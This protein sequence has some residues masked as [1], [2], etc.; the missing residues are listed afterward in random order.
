MPADRVPVRTPTASYD[1]R[2]GDRLLDHLGELGRSLELGPKV[3][4]VVDTGLPEDVIAR[5]SGALT[6]A[7]FDVRTAHVEP[8]EPN[9]TL[10]TT[11]RLCRTFAAHAIERT[12]TVVALGGGVVGDTAG[13]AAAVYRRGCR[14]LQCPTTLLSM[15]D[16]SVGGKTGVNLAGDD[17]HVRKNFVGAFLH[18][19]GVVADVG[20]LRSLP[21]RDLRA[22]AA[23]CVK[24]G[25][26]A[27]SAIGEAA[28]DFVRAQSADLP[29]AL[30]GDPEAATR[31][32]A[33]NVA[34]K[35]AV[36]AGDERETAHA[37]GRALL[38][39]GH[40]FAHVI[41]PMPACATDAGAG[42]LRHGEAVAI[43]LVAAS[44]CSVAL[45][46]AP[47]GFVDEARERL[48]GAGLP[49]SV[50]NLPPVDELVDAM[51]HD[52]KATAGQLRIVVPE[53]AHEAR[54]VRA[55]DPAALAA[56]WRAVEG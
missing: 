13:F 56:G 19:V 27:R 49:T 43:G 14:V 51:A 39:L 10:E 41:E 50:R 45:G 2:I 46:L 48:R 30:A 52:K 37:G 54:V 12:D 36:V 8:G 16:A 21:K 31:T 11:E 6:G 22:G 44:A 18:P 17:G 23:E 34:L 38:N 4:L 7:G 28:D 26:I 3:A 1:V 53:P 33:R 35:A 5:A 15:V 55:P 20:V 29:A 25:M 40:T 42:P 32:V 24:H 9:K 47:G